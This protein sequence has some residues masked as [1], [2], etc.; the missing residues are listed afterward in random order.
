M[1]SVGDVSIGLIASL[2]VCTVLYISVAL[3]LLGMEKYT[4]FGSNSEAVNAPVA[5]ALRHLGASKVFQSVII[6]GA[7]MGM[8]SSLL[9]FQYGQTRIWFAMSRDGLLP[10]LF[11]VVHKVH[12]TPHVSTWIAGLFVGIPA[13]LFSI[14][15]AADLS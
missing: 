9:V 4:V 14:S 1:T 7:L 10:K 15:E 13:G 12:N 8:I 3:V 11:S 5:Y 2:V 6:I